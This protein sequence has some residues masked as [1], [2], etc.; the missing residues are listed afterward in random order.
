MS[1]VVSFHSLCACGGLKSSQIRVLIKKKK[2]T[3]RE[4]KY[5]KLSVLTFEYDQVKDYFKVKWV[6]N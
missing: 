2:I 5:K 3:P 6:S 1:E 4:S